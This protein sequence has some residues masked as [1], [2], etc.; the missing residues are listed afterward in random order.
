MTS[1]QDAIGEKQTVTFQGGIL[2]DW[3]Q[4]KKDEYEL[5]EQAKVNFYSD[6]KTWEDYRAKTAELK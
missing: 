6:K 2:S 5:F 3:I 1:S 4:Q